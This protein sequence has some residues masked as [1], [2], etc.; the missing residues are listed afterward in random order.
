MP[1]AEY[2]AL[3]AILDL[4]E[5]EALEAGCAK[6]STGHL[7]IAL[8]RFA[9]TRE[10]RDALAIRAL[11]GEF[12]QLGIEPRRFRRRLRGI[13]GR[14]ERDPR[15]ST[16]PRAAAMQSVLDAAQL[17]ATAAGEAPSPVWLLRCAF[18]SLGGNVV[19][20]APQRDPDDAIAVEPSLGTLTQRLRALRTGLLARVCGQE[21]A[22]HAFVDGLFN[23]EVV[24]S[25]DTGRR[26]PAGLFVF[27]GPPGVGKT[28]L[29]ELGAASLERPFKRFDM[30]GYA[31]AHEASALTGSARMYRD[32]QPGS[33]TDFVRRNPTAVLLFDE[34]EKAHPSAVQLFLQVLD[35]GRLH[36]KYTEDE[37]AFR[38]TIVIFT[39]NVGRRLY[40]NDN[41]IGVYQAH[42]AFHRATVLDALR[43]ELDP[44]T[45][46]PFFPAA[47]C[48]RMATGHPVL[49]NRLRVDDLARIA[50][51]ELERVGRLLERQHGQRYSFGDEI[52]LALVMREGAAA[53]A[54]T[55]K[56][57]A[58][59]FL[60]DEI[61]KAC[62]LYSDERI[63]PAFQSMQTVAVEVDREHAGEAGQ[64]LFWQLQPPVVLYVGDPMLGRLHGQLDLQVT[65]CVAANAEQAFDQLARHNVDLVVLDLGLR[66]SGADYA[67]L[68]AAFGDLSAP[69]AAGT[70][71]D[72]DHIPP[73]A[74]R[75]AAGQQLLF[76]LRTRFPQLPV[77][78]H[79]TADARTGSDQELL[80]ACARAGGARGLIR[81]PVHS[82]EAA[83][84][85][86]DAAQ[87]NAQLQAICAQLRRE[88]TAAELAANNQVVAFDTA[89]AWAPEQGCL[90]IRC[91]NFRL[92]HALRSA[93]AGALIAQLE[94]PGTRFDD[95]IGANG[96]KQ[97]LSFIRD[98]LRDPKKFAAAGAEPPRGVLLT[99]APGAG[100]TMLARALAGESECAFLA[101]A[102][103][104]FVTRY[105]GSGPEAIRELFTRARRYAPSVVFI[106]EI[107]AIGGRRAELRAGYAGH[108]EAL[109]LN[110]LLVEMDG[111]GQPTA[112]P[113]IVIA[114]TNRADTLDPALMRRFSRSIEVELPTRAERSLYLRRRLA[115]KARH[116]VGDATI[117]RLAAQGQGMSVADYERIL[118]QAAILALE[119][120]GIIDDAILA[121]AFEQVT[122]GEARSSDDPLRVARHEA[123]H[124]LIMCATGNPPVYLTIVGRGSFG[125][126]AAF[127]DKDERRARTRRELEDHICQLLGGR[128]AEQLYYGTDEGASTGPADDLAR[129]TWVAEAMVYDYGMAPEVGFVRI[130]RRQSL[131]AELAQR[132]HGAVCRIIETQGSR[133]RGLLAAQHA[134][135]ERVVGALVE[136]NRLQQHELLELLALPRPAESAAPPS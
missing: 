1:A 120:Q 16:V 76:A 48:S 126:Y 3:D 118:A 4:A 94:R 77:Y 117:E 83:Q 128:E 20:A 65:W 104:G 60:K 91:R 73:A 106:D 30:S 40:E 50:S 95:I 108:G 90:Q 71:L 10:P 64:R 13:L 115:A 99:G 9:E 39:T 62:Q 78:V 72:F 127:E 110:Q 70:E 84:G 63:D 61:F 14:R 74:R 88:A 124:A 24:V 109:A 113:V 98:W 11:N 29:A 80:V 79:C 135:L 38:D 87:P 35:S 134:G 125:G 57:Q 82:L 21:H 52:A 51:A 129:A 86:P 114:A 92:M 2:G 93:D 85:E 19:S 26:Q 12:E 100:K 28:F 89:P 27:A 132:A 5:H 43:C 112:R 32:A 102:A 54:R 53:D 58:E 15:A 96:A 81:L 6:T 7:L 101:E 121:E 31:H 47:I 23:V 130:D 49:F 75:Y 59:A 17:A 42:A 107:D 41:A 22:V 116:E 36:D 46:V 103:T 97:A 33:L 122:L 131:P 37:V 8:S 111:F 34:I 55:I 67:D 105:Q 66:A 136:R 119:N 45:G 56:A 25:A 69:A 123:G 68:G 133:A 18:A 44:H